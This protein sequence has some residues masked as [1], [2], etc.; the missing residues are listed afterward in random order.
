VAILCDIRKE[1]PKVDL[2]ALTLGE[3]TVHCL[4]RD[5]RG[6]MKRDIEIVKDLG[7]LSQD[8][9]LERYNIMRKDSF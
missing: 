1:Y 3:I 7:P 8:S 6:K 5:K 2:A 4:I 9:V